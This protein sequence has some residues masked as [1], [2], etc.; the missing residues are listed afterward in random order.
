MENNIENATKAVELLQQVDVSDIFSSLALSIADAQKR[1]DDNS[2]AQ[3]IKLGEQQIKGSSLIELGFVPAFYSFTEAN[4]SA[5]LNLKLAMK[6]SIGGGFNASG[7]YNSNANQAENYSDYSKQTSYQKEKASFKSSRKFMIAAESKKSI[8][9]NENHYKLEE[10]LEIVSRIDKLHNEILEQQN[11]DRVN[12]NIKNQFGTKYSYTNDFTI[13]KITNYSGNDVNKDST[14]TTTVTDIKNN[15]ETVFSS[16]AGNYGF[17]KDKFIKSSSGPLE[18]LSIY[19][20]LDKRWINPSYKEETYDNTDGRMGA[21]AALADVLR[22]DKSLSI[23]V[24]GYTD[25]SASDAYNENLSKD[26]CEAMRN[27]FIARGADKTQIK[28]EPKGET[29]AVENGASDNTKNPKF[30]K[31]TIQLENN[32]DYIYF[33]TKLVSPSPKVTSS[34]DVNYFLNPILETTAKDIF[35]NINATEIASSNYFS[36]DIAN[37]TYYLKKDTKIEYFLYSK[38]SEEINIRAEEGAEEE[39]KVSENE[40]SKELESSSDGNANKDK[41]WA[42]SGSLDVRSSKQFEMS[43]EGNASMSAKLVAIPAPEAFIKILKP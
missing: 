32:K 15:L 30:R 29:L 19:F 2:I 5:S 40:N 9:I 13:L 1:L 31:V 21:I 10:N 42:V 8:I 12:I 34:T 28:V 27:W 3:A 37:T 43:M 38:T 35:I 16:I 14:T 20:G 39:V 7:T 36:Q 33:N 18:E 24:Y 4:I 26:R 41:K 11:I 17:N 25:S 23:T 22:E 6:T